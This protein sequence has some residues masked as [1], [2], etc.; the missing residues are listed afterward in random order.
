[1]VRKEEIMRAIAEK[2]IGCV[3][4]GLLFTAGSALPSLGTETAQL[5]DF[6]GPWARNAFNFEP[7]PS[8]PAPLMN[9]KRLP[10]G[11]G[12]PGQLVGDYHN[13]ILKPDVAEIVKKKGEI[14]ISGEAYPDPSN[15]C[16]PYAPPF[17]FAM[18]LGLQILQ[19]K[20]AITIIYNQDDQVRRVRLNASHPAHVTPTAMG[21]SIGH[22]EGDTL[23]VD[24]VSV[25][26]GP[27][28]LVDRYGTPRSDAFHLV[29]RYR[30]IDGAAAKEAQ[31]RHEKQD[32][33]VGGPPGAMAVD[34][35][36]SV[37]GLQVLVTV[38]DPKVF[39]TP[40]SANI[41]YRRS[42]TQ[43]QEQVCAENPIEISGK[44][45]PIPMADKS[46]F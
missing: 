23:V 14:S 2:S 38:E 6:S 1:M 11:T 20:D 33:R 40:W 25:K 44:M 26:T 42:K 15:H 21:D 46:D 3:V 7:L 8:G 34:P 4:A 16:G 22:Y 19:K 39:T 28:A 36:T 10:D 30:L 27:L 18:Q 17:N 13:P 9:L 5:P 37:K 45:T 24:T 35:D 41:T 31:D 29:E 32:G 12:D 43:W